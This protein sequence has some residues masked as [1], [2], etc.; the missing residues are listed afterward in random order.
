MDLK[1]HITEHHP[2][3]YRCNIFSEA[4]NQSWKIESHTTLHKKIESFKCI[5]CE[6][7]HMEGHNEQKK[8][9][10]LKSYLEVVVDKYLSYRNVKTLILLM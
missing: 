8:F 2:K 7:K 3:S 1:G 10:H 4:F 5:Q 9:C 6:K